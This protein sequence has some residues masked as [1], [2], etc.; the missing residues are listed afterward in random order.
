MDECLNGQPV[1][2]ESK[3][4][5]DTLA[6]RANHG[7]MAKLLAL[8]HIG[9]MH[10]D[11]GGRDAEDAVVQGDTGMR[12]GA[13]IEHHSVDTE[14]VVLQTVDELALD[15]ALLIGYLDSRIE[16]PQLFQVVLKGAVPIDIGFTYT[17]QIKVG[18]I[19]DENFHTSL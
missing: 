7:M 6:S 14:A 2:I 18:P 10:L 1:G 8:M 12:V 9:D 3:A 15:V 16:G 17:Q 19:D 4:R 5:N 11:H 13:C